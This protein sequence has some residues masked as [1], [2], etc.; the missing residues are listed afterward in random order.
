MLPTFKSYVI[1]NNYTFTIFIFDN[2]N[3]FG[4]SGNGSPINYE[5]A[6]NLKNNY[7]AELDITYYM[8]TKLLEREIAIEYGKDGIALLDRCLIDQLVYP[9]VLLNE[10]YQNPFFDYVKLW[11]KIHPYKHIF[12]I[13]KNYELLTKYGT[14]DK[15]IYYVDEIEKK[16]L[17]VIKELGIEYTILSENQ[18]EQIKKIIEYLT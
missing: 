11:I 13:P 5:S 14:K 1:N 6:S 17:E 15:S 7:I 10:N 16:Y 9:A 2:I 12:Y 18:E 8:I 4:F 3:F